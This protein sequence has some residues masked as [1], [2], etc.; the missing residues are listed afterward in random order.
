MRGGSA[1]TIKRMHSGRKPL[2]G[3]ITN[4]KKSINSERPIRLLVQGSFD[5]AADKL[6]QEAIEV[7]AL[8]DRRFQVNFNSIETLLRSGSINQQ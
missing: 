2:M 6:E 5:E 7:K 3:Y 1:H 8:I 4:D